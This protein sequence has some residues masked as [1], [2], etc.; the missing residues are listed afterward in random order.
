MKLGIDCTIYQMYISNVK[1]TKFKLVKK[2]KS[3]KLGH[4][5][6]QQRFLFL[7]PKFTNRN[8]KIRN[9]ISYT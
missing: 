8:R 4:L 9:I 3:R 5:K 2:E 6:R 1:W 7:I